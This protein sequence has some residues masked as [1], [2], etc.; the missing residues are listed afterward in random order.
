MCELNQAVEGFAG[1]LAALRDAVRR[2]MAATPDLLDL[3]KCEVLA[4]HCDELAKMLAPHKGEAPELVLIAA[5]SVDLKP[6][7]RVHHLNKRMFADLDEVCGGDPQKVERYLLAAAMLCLRW[8]F[9]YA[10]LLAEDLASSD[11]P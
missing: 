2:A 1:K 4:W 11:E 10:T 8:G 9:D 5:P 7:E 3:P 6:D